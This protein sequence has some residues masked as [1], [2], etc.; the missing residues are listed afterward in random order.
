MIVPIRHRHSWLTTGRG[1]LIGAALCLG[2]ASCALLSQLGTPQGSTITAVTYNIR[3]G[4]G[5]DDAL[6][7]ERTAATLR[8]LEADFIALE[9][10]DRNVRRSG[11]VDQ[12]KLLGDL[13]GMKAA[14]GPF[15]DYQDGEYGLAILS[16][17]PIVRSTALRLPDGNEPRVALLVQVTL[18]NGDPLTV[19]S[20]HF[21]WVSDDGFRFAQAKVLAATLDTLSTPYLLMGD[22]NDEPGSRTIRLFERGAMEAEKPREGHLTFPAAPAPVKEIDFVFV[23]PAMRWRV[24][25]VAVVDERMAS[26]HRPVMARLLLRK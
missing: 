3:H 2:S 26:D 7:L 4:V 21:D 5:M 14:F 12:A 23:S 10:V 17:H 11:S 15:M 19:V 25:S 22:F 13:L 16:K 1:L 20:V 24:D 6:R 18:P 8:P 9:E